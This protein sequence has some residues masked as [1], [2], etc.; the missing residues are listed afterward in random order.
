[1]LDLKTLKF[2]SLQ[3]MKVAKTFNGTVHAHEGCIYAMGGNEKDACEKYDT[4]A[5]KWELIQS[6]NDICKANE[7]NGWVQIFCPF[8]IV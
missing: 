7:L 6:Y 2:N 1:M 4:Y 8:G 5:N 3:E